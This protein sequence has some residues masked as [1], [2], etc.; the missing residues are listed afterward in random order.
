LE[1]FI[2]QLVVSSNVQVPTL[3]S[4]V[5]Y[6]SRLKARLQPL[7]NGLRCTTH[8]IF[9]AS[10]ILAAKYLNDS[11]PKNKHWA[12]YRFIQSEVHNFGFSRTEVNLMEN[13]LLSLLGWELRITES[14]LYRELEPFLAPIRQDIAERYI[15]RQRRKA[16]ERARRRGRALDRG[17]PASQ[18]RAESSRSNTPAVPHPTLVAGSLAVAALRRPRPLPAR[19]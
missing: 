19:A 5:V 15:R 2:T 9:L 10:L 16:E 12:S 14:D 4:T 1:E 18:H 8:R 7:A 13:Q 17:A 6:L 3:M 11:S